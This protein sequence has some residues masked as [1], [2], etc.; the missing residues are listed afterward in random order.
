MGGAQL[1]LALALLIDQF[2]QRVEGVAEGGQGMC[3]G[4]DLVRP[5]GGDRNSEV[6]AVETIHRDH[7]PT[8]RNGD[9]P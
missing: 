4:A 2:A 8:Q 3:H 7:Q 1:A 5:R 6:A 9:R